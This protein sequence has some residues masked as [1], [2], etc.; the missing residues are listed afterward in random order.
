MCLTNFPMEGVGDG[1]IG[2]IP[3]HTNI[4][5]GRGTM[6]RKKISNNDNLMSIPFYSLLY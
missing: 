2:N 1:L 4:R 5:N 6:I 3:F